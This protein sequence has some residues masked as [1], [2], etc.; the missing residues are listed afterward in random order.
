MQFIK[1]K[2]PSIVKSK[3]SQ[4]QKYIPKNSFTIF[5]NQIK[6]NN[7]LQSFVQNIVIHL[8]PSYKG[9]ETQQMGNV[10]SKKWWKNKNIF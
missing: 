3:S 8:S 2:V 9:F 5:Y 4:K 7:S 10:S 6:Y 1:Y